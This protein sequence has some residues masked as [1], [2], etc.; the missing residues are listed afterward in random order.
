MDVETL[1]ARSQWRMVADRGK[2]GMSFIASGLFGIPKKIPMTSMYGLKTVNSDTEF[3]YF[4]RKYGFETYGSDKLE[5]DKW[6]K[7]VWDMV[8]GDQSEGLL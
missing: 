3:E 1:L 2:N 7:E 4:L 5:L 6:P 8:G